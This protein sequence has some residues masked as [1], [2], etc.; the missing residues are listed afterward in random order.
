MEK[1]LVRI[2][3]IDAKLPRLEQSAKVADINT[4][5]SREEQFLRTEVLPYFKDF[6]TVRS[7]P[8]WKE[9]LSRDTGKGYPIGILL[10]TYRE[11]GDAAG[12]RA[13]LGGFYEKRNK[14]SLDSL[15]VP[16]KSAAD[17]PNTGSPTKMKA[18]EYKANLRAMTSKRMSKQDWEAY[19]VRWDQ[20]LQAGNVEMDT[21][22][23]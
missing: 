8:E 22:L 1:Q 2:K 6:E 13:V 15:A 9:Y 23:R 17:T 16:A 11:Q 14:P 4:A 20:A 18:S 3:D 5:R 7:T 21:E 10:K 12:I 19:R